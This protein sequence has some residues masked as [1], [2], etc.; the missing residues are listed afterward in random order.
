MSKSR[1]SVRGNSTKQNSKSFSK[2]RI[3]DEEAD[4]SENDFAETL[5]DFQTSKR[6]NSNDN[7]SALD[8]ISDSSIQQDI[9]QKG[10]SIKNRDSIFERKNKNEKIENKENLENS[11]EEDYSN[12]TLS[13]KKKPLQK[14]EKEKQIK[15]PTKMNQ[16]RSKKETV[17]FSPPP[18]LPP[19]PTNQDVLEETIDPLE[20]ILG[21]DLSLKGRK[22]PSPEIRNSKQEIRGN[23]NKQSES[24]SEEKSEHVDQEEIEFKERS[25]D[26]Y[27]DLGIGERSEDEEDNTSFH[28]PINERIEREDQ[29]EME[30]L[31]QLKTQLFTKKDSPHKKSTNTNKSTSTNK[32]KTKNSTKSKTQRKNP[33]RKGRKKAEEEE[34]LDDNKEESDLVEEKTTKIKKQTNNKRKTQTEKQKSANLKSEKFENRTSKRLRIAPLKFWEGERVIYGR[35]SSVGVPVIQEILRVDK[36]SPKTPIRKKSLPVEDLDTPHFKYKDPKSNKEIVRTV[37]KPSKKAKKRESSSESLESPEKGISSS[38]IET[39]KIIIKANNTYF[40]KKSPFERIYFIADCSK[41]K[42]LNIIID[43]KK[44]MCLTNHS[45]FVI[46]PNLSFSVKNHAPS[47]VASILQISTKN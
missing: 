7:Y 16:T 4:S 15:T 39:E 32:S 40:G 22:S 6:D 34:M 18:S 37:A 25:E 47:K 20:K 43:K 2:S 44:K 13:N 38:S 14:N 10:G 36:K 26:G 45:Q 41:A 17:D 31:N 1:S 30:E 33:Q 23:K 27:Q 12:Q 21:N 11:V 19:S 9:F 29:I 42:G 28:L 3:D 46:P 24:E 8:I 5:N 35:R